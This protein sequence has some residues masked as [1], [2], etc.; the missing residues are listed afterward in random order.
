MTKEALE[1]QKGND[2]IPIFIGMLTKRI[3]MR[4]EKPGMT[5]KSGND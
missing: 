1:W 5:R 3:G 4:K 2:C